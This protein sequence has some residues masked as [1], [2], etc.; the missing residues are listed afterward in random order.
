MIFFSCKNAENSNE[1]SS[2]VS[3]A[4]NDASHEKSAYSITNS[5]LIIIDKTKIPNDSTLGKWLKDNDKFI[6]KHYSFDPNIIAVDINLMSDDG[7]DNNNAKDVAI[8]LEDNNKF[9][10]F[11][12]T[13][14]FIDENHVVLDGERIKKI[15]STVKKL[16]LNSVVKDSI[17]LDELVKEID[18]QVKVMNP[19]EEYDKVFYPFYVNFS[20]D[21]SGTVI[22]F[23]LKKGYSANDVSL[24]IPAIKSIIYHNEIPQ[25]ELSK[26][27]VKYSYE[28]NTSSGT[29]TD[30]IALTIYS[31]TTKKTKFYNYS[32]DPTK[33]TTIKSIKYYNAY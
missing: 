33:K 26:Y 9:I 16:K 5:S 1:N 10:D 31:E 2:D 19:S 4:N 12:R 29:V 21:T 11:K 18:R 23:K 3:D 20:I 15:N 6:I 30:Q 7:D 28:R 14:E 22:D 32:T 27:H 24:S 17:T 25:T 8:W 13:Y